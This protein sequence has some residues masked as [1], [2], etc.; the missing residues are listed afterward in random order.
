MIGCRKSTSMKLEVYQLKDSGHSIR[1]IAQI[2]GI[3]KN[4]V[5]GILKNRETALLATVQIPETRSWS[6]TIP[7]DEVLKELSKR[8]VTI[9]QLAIEYAP[10][11]IDYLRFWRELNRRLPEDLAETVRIRM[12]H[13]PGDRFEIDYTDGLLITDRKSGRTL[14]TQLF[15][16]VSSSSDYTYAEFTLKQKQCEFISSQNRMFQFFGGVPKYLVVDNLKSGVFRAHRYDPDLNA[17]YC[18][19][20]NHMGFAVLPARPATPRDKPA[21]EGTIGVIQRQFYAEMRNR[22]FYSLSELN[23]EL[24]K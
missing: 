18:E 21:I 22:I 7:W 8:Y 2:L 1:K 17:T 15:A 19:Y 20:A 14:K 13:E 5:K 16:A 9:K 23:L 3:S 24:S 12:R 6:E 11:G 4:T 10:E